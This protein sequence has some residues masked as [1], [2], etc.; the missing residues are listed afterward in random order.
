MDRIKNVL[1]ERLGGFQVDEYIIIA[2]VC[3][4]FL[5]YVVPVALIVGVV[6]YLLIKKRLFLIIKEVPRAKFAVVFCVITTGVA[7]CYGN[8]LGALCGLGLFVVFLFTFYYRTI[9]NKR[10]F[11]VIL[12][13]CCVLSLL[14]IVWAIFQY[15]SICNRNNISVFQFKILN[16]PENRIYAGFFNANYY[17][18]FIEFIILICVYRVIQLKRLWNAKF[19]IGIA[20]CNMIALYFTGCRTA[21]LPFLIT[22]PFMF[23]INKCKAYF[24]LSLTGIAGAFSLLLLKP[25]LFQRITLGKDMDKRLLIWKTALKGIEAHPLFGEGPLTYYQI[26]PLY[27]GHP[28]QHAHSVYLDP[29][30]SHGLIPVC[31]FAIYLGSNLKQVFY[32]IKR[33]IDIPLFSLI[34]GVILTVLIHG[35]LD[36]TVYWVQTGIL[37]LLIISSSSI[38]FQKHSKKESSAKA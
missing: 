18:M 37:F 21:W 15:I 2:V 35:V 26:Y 32:L 4:L 8:Y 22:V 11:D 33:R 31:I 6:I 25:E 3:S 34:G 30:L 14:S 23:L 29:I 9:I 28:T 1:K 13:I 5:P 27:N 20:L 7:L 16:K 38:Y 36:Y 24:G 12:D 17:A 19:Y 10:L